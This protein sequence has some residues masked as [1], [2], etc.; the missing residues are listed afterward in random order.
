M[1]VLRGLASIKWADTAPCVMSIGNFDGMHLGHQA[2]LKR[3]VALAKAEGLVSCVMLFEPQPKEY[4]DPDQAPPRLMRLI[5]K[6]RYL[7]AYGIDQV[8]CLRFDQALVARTAEAFCQT[9]LAP[10]QARR[11][12][13]GENFRFGAKRGGDCETLKQLGKV[14]GW[15]LEAMPMTQ[16]SGGRVSSTR[17]R[18]ALQ[19]D[20]LEN[21]ESLLG[22]AYAIAGRVRRGVQR[23]RELGYPTLNLRLP[24]VRCAVQGIYAVEVF[25]L[26]HSEQIFQGAASIGINP[27]W[28]LPLPQLEVHVLDFDQ[29]V[30]GAQVEVRFMRYL[31]AEQKFDSVE[32]LV[33]QIEDDIRSVRQG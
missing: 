21:T 23:G 19:S 8:V 33:L 18:A 27:C 1:R 24:S 10:L 26:A 12:C 5:D 20:D 2:L 9:V 17:V 13:V 29:M 31:R 11:I 3:T 30:Y 4:F 32:A 22:R 28:P 6:L 16:L 14:H 7:K 25:F 15:Q